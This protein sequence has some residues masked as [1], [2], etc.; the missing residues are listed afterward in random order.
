VHV[1]PAGIAFV[2]EANAAEQVNHSYVK[3]G[4]G[5]A[6]VHVPDDTV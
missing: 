5:T 2:A 1:V 3:D 4:S 6:P